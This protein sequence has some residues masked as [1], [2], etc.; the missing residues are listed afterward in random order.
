[1]MSAP[2]PVSRINGLLL[3][4][5][6]S[7]AGVAPVSPSDAD[8]PYEAH[9]WL[10]LR[11]VLEPH[12]IVYDCGAAHGL[13]S[14][15]IATVV[16]Q[17]E[18]HAFEANPDVLPI[19]RDVLEK[20]HAQVVLNTV[21]VGERSGIEVEFYRAPGLSCVASSRHAVVASVHSQATVA[22]VPVVALD[23]YAAARGHW[24]D[25]L[26]IDIEG[27][28]YVALQGAARILDRRPHLLIET[29]PTQM[30]GEGASLEALCS[31]LETLGYPLF[32][33][34]SGVVMSGHHFAAAYGWLPGYVMASMRL[35]EAGFVERLVLRHREMKARYADRERHQAAIAQA[36][37]MLD[38]EPLQAVP[39][40]EEV[41]RQTPQH[42]EAHYLLAFALQ[43][44]RQDAASAR[45][46]YDAALAHGFD[47]FWVHYNLGALLLET[48]DRMAAGEHLRKAK[49]LNPEH[50]GVAFYLRQL[51]GLA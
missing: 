12:S 44:A 34:Q 27:S 51:A 47:A 40:L 9:S 17:G 42:A 24:P 3:H 36:R 46:H 5:P 18:I 6:Q 28:E 25:V 29:H 31:W 38:S 37:K 35:R 43:S 22:R 8:F 4:I 45:Q 50:D 11:A 15:M 2:N 20:N 19:T 14:A 1:M 30:I 48:G 16:T 13:V 23:D 21:C 26:K 41:L 7:L 39:L 49:A 10:G 33:L 32:D